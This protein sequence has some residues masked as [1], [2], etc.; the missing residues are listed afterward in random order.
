[1]KIKK[2]WIINNGWL[3]FFIGFFVAFND[4]DIASYIGFGLML[5]SFYLMYLGSK[6]EKK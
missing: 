2:N 3:V 4:N 6:Q 5:F 1:M